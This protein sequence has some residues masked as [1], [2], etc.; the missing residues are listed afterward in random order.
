MHV[1]TALYMCHSIFSSFFSELFYFEP[2][3]THPLLCKKKS[4]L[5][6]F[7]VFS[8]FLFF[9]RRDGTKIMYKTTESSDIEH[10]LSVRAGNLPKLLV[11][12]QKIHA[13]LLKLKIYNNFRAKK[14]GQNKA[15][16]K[17]PH[18]QHVHRINIAQ[19]HRIVEAKRIQNTSRR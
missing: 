4:L 15:G 10:V 12:S 11:F 5:P 16:P 9:W 2:P 13:K 7:P 3:Q 1:Y 18:T 17:S 19:H 14:I 6:F 8:V